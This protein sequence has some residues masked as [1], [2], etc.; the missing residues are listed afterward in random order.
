MMIDRLVDLIFKSDKLR[1]AIFAE[2]DWHNSITRI[3][4][5]PE[6]MK[7]TN[8][9]W[10]DIEGWR[11]WSLKDNGSYYFHDIPEKGLSDLMNILLEREEYA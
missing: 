5:D 4:A 8:A 1:S 10:C 11:G 3:L 6:E 9:M 2:V 7:T